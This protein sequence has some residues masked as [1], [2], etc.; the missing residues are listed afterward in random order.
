MIFGEFINNVA[1][2]MGTTDEMAGIFISLLITVSLMLIIEIASRGKGYAINGLIV[3]VVS[4]MMFT[5]MEW[6]P[7]WTGGAL[8][9][10]FSLIAAMIMSRTGA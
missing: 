4:T 9:L 8:A 10:G 5:A 1:S 2:V 3:A 7:T 6:L